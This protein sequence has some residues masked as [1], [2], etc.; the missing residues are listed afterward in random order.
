MHRA[1]VVTFFHFLLFNTYL[2]E[3]IMF[4][5]KN[6][7]TENVDKRYSDTNRSMAGILGHFKR[8]SLKKRRKFVMKR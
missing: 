8:E 4:Y 6:A 2:F 3:I 5:K 7:H 1:I